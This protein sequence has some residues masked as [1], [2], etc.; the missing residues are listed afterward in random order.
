[1]TEIT[2]FIQTKTQSTAEVIWG[3]GFDDEL[4]DKISVTI[5]AT[6]FDEDH[7]QKD[8][9]KPVD[10]KIHDL[11]DKAANT[12]KVVQRL[13]NPEPEVNP[14]PE[15]PVPYQ[16]IPLYPV[17]E[18]KTEEIRIISAIPESMA[19]EEE[20]A[21]MEMESTERTMEFIID[22]VEPQAIIEPKET[23]VHEFQP[24][25][26]MEEPA[27]VMN[28]IP[29]PSQPAE[30]PAQHDYSD[31]NRKVNERVNKLRALSEKLKNLTPA[32]SNLYELESVP[33][34]KR[35]NIELNDV[36]PS[37]ESQVAKFMLSENADKSVELK[38]E[39]SFLHKKVD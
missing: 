9:L 29:Q 34:Y 36:A 12:P 39:N 18:E 27:P 14:V 19:M 1:V 30:A 23:L 13:I 15:I 16:A 24:E 4:E 10:V 21:S 11:Y 35:R 32:E 26:V 22:H 31:F 17:Q 5:I 7:K 37:A 6:G 3:N 20:P 28:R 25:P 33:A 2:D 38:T 8:P